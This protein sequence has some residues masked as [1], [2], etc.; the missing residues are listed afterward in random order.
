MQNIINVQGLIPPD[1]FTEFKDNNEKIEFL[2]K[3]KL[4]PK[5]ESELR[6][7]FYRGLYSDDYCIC[8]VVGYQSNE[9]V[10]ISLDN[11][12]HC[13]NKD[14]LKEMQPYVKDIDNFTNN[15]PKY[16]IN[17]KQES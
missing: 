6:P 12:L 3:A 8:D 14:C 9:T 1:D 5:T 4:L 17:R 11:H 13:I 15:I 10:V 7:L 16:L 2:K